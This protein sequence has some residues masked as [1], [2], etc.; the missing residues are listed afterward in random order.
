VDAVITAHRGSVGVTSRPGQTSF[1][2]RLPRLEDEPE[3]AG[4]TQPRLRTHSHRYR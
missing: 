2:I 4:T 1:T 3:L